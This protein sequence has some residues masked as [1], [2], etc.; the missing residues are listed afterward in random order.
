MPPC[1]RCNDLDLNTIFSRKDIPDRR[2]GYS[3]AAISRL[4]RSC[5]Q[6]K[7]PMCCFLAC[8]TS[9]LDKCLIAD[10]YHL[11]ALNFRTL[12]GYEPEENVPRDWMVLKLVP[13]PPIEEYPVQRIYEGDLIIPLTQGYGSFSEAN[14][15]IGRRVKRNEVDYRFLRNCIDRCVSEHTGFCEP[16]TGAAASNMSVIDCVT[17]DVVKYTGGQYAALSYCIGPRGINPARRKRFP[18][19]VADAI[20]CTKTLGYYYL[21]VDQY[22]INQ[23]DKA[24]LDAAIAQMHLIYS[25]ATVTIISLGESQDIALPGIGRRR[26]YSQAYLTTNDGSYIS[27]MSSLLASTSRSNWDKRGWCFQEAILSTRVLIF[28]EDQV[29]Y[30]CGLCDKSEAFNDTLNKPRDALSKFRR[31][32]YLEFVEAR[33]NAALFTFGNWLMSYTPKNLTFEGDVLNAMRGVLNV[34]SYYT[35]WG[36][37]FVGYDHDSPFDTT[38]AFIAG[39]AWSTLYNGDADLYGRKA[40]EQVPLATAR[41]C[42]Y[43]RSGFPSWS[44]ASCKPYNTSIG[45]MVPGGFSVDD[46]KEMMSINPVPGLEIQVEDETGR[47]VPMDVFKRRS[48]NSSDSKCLPETASTFHIQTESFLTAVQPVE[49]FD[50]LDR[51]QLWRQQFCLTLSAHNSSG[52]A[53]T[54]NNSNISS[55]ARLTE[56]S[57]WE[58][59]NGRFAIDFDVPATTQDDYDT[60]VAKRI[61]PGPDTVSKTS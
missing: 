56:G 47:T 20:V 38:K 29:H 32:E 11:R 46:E 25:Q 33:R 48:C 3:V 6:A 34:A 1:P 36:I 52:P 35:W 53:S 61:F 21:W 51:S 30:L 19:V 16:L 15:C 50:K 27:T 43:R 5:R 41:P 42:P 8:S 55:H 58:V 59:E 23:H 45:Y 24:E 31:P 28:A 22:C 40:D 60:I 7:C 14:T 10:E 12:R 9:I 37:P 18:A 26:T 17:G 49:D 44:W 2:H 4:S 57:F 39:L 13:E 54:N